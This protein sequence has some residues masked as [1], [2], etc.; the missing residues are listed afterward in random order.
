MGNR[1]I[2]IIPFCTITASGAKFNYR[3]EGVRP[4]LKLAP[5]L[6]LGK[7]KRFAKTSI[8]F[9]FVKL[10]IEKFMVTPRLATRQCLAQISILQY[11]GRCHAA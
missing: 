5:F 1:A 11:F 4:W 10:V 9:C 6:T 7:L 8:G 2:H 3:I